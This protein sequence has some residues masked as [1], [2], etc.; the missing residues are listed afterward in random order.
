MMK[1]NGP[2]GVTHRGTSFSMNEM[3]S[4]NTESIMELPNKNMD[5]GCIK[6]IG[7]LSSH[8]R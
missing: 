1:L 2:S 5:N 4:L 7:R 6:V 8:W 3:K